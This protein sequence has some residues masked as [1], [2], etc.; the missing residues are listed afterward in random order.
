MA[1]FTVEQAHQLPL[2]E[3]KQRLDAFLARMAT[4]MGGKHTW[5]SE[6]EARIEHSLAKAHLKLEPTRAVVDVEGGMAL[7]L[8]KGKVQSRIQ[9]SL[10]DALTGTKPA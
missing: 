5:T 2:P 6:S 9:Q 7:A 10:A 8:V 4:K 3:A 1:K